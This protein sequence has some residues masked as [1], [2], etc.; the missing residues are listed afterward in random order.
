MEQTLLRCRHNTRLREKGNIETFRGI[1]V[2]GK[3]TNFYYEGVK[4]SVILTREKHR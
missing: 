4:A 1:T 2:E 3:T